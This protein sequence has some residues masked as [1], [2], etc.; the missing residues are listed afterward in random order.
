MPGYFRVYNKIAKINS[1]IL[2]CTCKCIDKIFEPA[3]KITTKIFRTR[4]SMKIAKFN[5]RENNPVYG[6]KLHNYKTENKC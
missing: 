6:I 3:K 5:T 2:K 1:A 4:H